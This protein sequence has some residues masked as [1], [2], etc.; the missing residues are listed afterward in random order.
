MCNIGQNQSLIG[1]VFFRP[2]FDL[3]LAKQLSAA[4][5]EKDISSAAQGF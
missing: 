4:K 2:G 1:A 3:S 5:K